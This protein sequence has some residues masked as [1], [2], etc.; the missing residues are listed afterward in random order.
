MWPSWP[1]ACIRPGTVER[2]AWSF[3]SW[4]GSASMSARRSTVRVGSPGKPSP[5][6]T[7]TTPVP[8]TPVR[9]SIAPSSARRPATTA[10]VRVS[11]NPSSGWRCNSRRV[12]TS[13]AS[14][15]A[16][17]SPTEIGPAVRFLGCILCRPPV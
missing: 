11:S 12:V 4:I 6:R 5:R 9:T 10:A 14:S 2:Y 17:L 3:S 8:A 7:P 16:T 13:S 1:Q 15:A